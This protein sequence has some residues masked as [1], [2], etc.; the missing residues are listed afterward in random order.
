MIPRYGEP[1]QGKFRYRLRAGVY[2][3]VPRGGRLLLTY[4]SAPQPEF[5]LPGGGVDAG[6]SPLQALH[7]EVIEETG[8]RIRPLY[9][10]GAFRRF[11]FMPEYHLWAEKIC[12]IWLA[13]PIFAL[14]APKEAFHSAHW[15]LADEA[16][17]LLENPGDRAM[18]AA[19]LSKGLV[20]AP[21]SRHYLG[22]QTP[23]RNRRAK[24][25]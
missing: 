16:L 22:K 6:E 15:V 1:P 8:W 3:I 11:V 23:R 12:S 2:A 13:A 7:R 14:G 5:Q 24:K 10:L 17:A 18:L 25:P 4:Q 19:A 20:E 21:D 9:R